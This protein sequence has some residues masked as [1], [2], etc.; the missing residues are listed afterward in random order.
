MNP[1]IRLRLSIVAVVALLLVLAG[2]AAAGD[3]ATFSGRMDGTVTVTPLAPPYE[4][5]Q[6]DAVGN[7]TE[8]GRFTL[9]M[10]HLVNLALGS[11]E[12]SFLFTAANGDALTADFSGQASLV[13]PGVVAIHEQAV[14][15]GGSGRFAG[16]TG[17]FV[18]DRMFYPA[19]G[20]TTGSFAG[21]IST[22]RQ[23]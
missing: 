2:P 11:G 18:A 22:P 7:A 9:A 15:T 12:G 8:L 16:A 3:Q 14:I 19:T 1:S 13:A 20:E 23:R 17:S 6:I 10:P 21:T 4:S 5:V